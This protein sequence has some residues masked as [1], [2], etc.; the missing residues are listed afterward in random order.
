VLLTNDPLGVPTGQPTINRDE[1]VYWEES[2]IVSRYE[3]GISIIGHYPTD[4]PL[5]YTF[6]APSM[7]ER[8]CQAMGTA[9]MW[10]IL[11]PEVVE[12]SDPYIFRYRSPSEYESGS[13]YICGSNN[14]AFSL[15]FSSFIVDVFLAVF[16]ADPASTVLW[17]SS[18]FTIVQSSV[19]ITGDCIVRVPPRYSNRG[20]GGIEYGVKS[21][22]DSNVTSSAGSIL[23]PDFRR[24]LHG[25]IESRVPVFLKVAI[26]DSIKTCKSNPV[27]DI[28][29][30]QNPVRHAIV[31]ASSS[32]N[33]MA[34][35][36][37]MAVDGDARTQWLSSYSNTR[38]DPSPWISIHFPFYF[39]ISEYSF[40]SKG[41]SDPFVGQRPRSWE[42][43]ASRDGFT[44]K[45]LD[46]RSGK[47]E[48]LATFEVAN[49]NEFYSLYRFHFNQNNGWSWGHSCDLTVALFEINFYGIITCLS[50]HI[51][52]T[53]ARLCDCDNLC[54][55][56]VHF[57][58]T[59]LPT[60]TPTTIPQSS[61][62]T[63]Q[64]S[65][66]REND[67]RY[68]RKFPGSAHS[69][70]PCLGSLVFHNFAEGFSV[71]C[72]QYRLQN[73]Y[74]L[75][76]ASTSKLHS[77]INK[78]V[79]SSFFACAYGLQSK[80]SRL[81]ARVA[82]AES[83]DGLSTWIFQ[84]NLDR[85]S[86]EA[87]NLAHMRALLFLKGASIGYNQSVTVLSLNR[88]AL[89]ADGNILNQTLCHLRSTPFL[90][91]L[92]SSV[93]APMNV[94]IAHTSSWNTV[95]ISE[96]LLCLLSSSPSSPVPILLMLIADT[97]TDDDISSVSI[98]AAYSDW[99]TGDSTEEGPKIIVYLR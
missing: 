83:V 91:A 86:I 94:H 85:S 82:V 74:V 75:L 17:F 95:D 18:N 89:G 38:C 88:D 66:K 24:A 6:I 42:L 84:M 99:Y 69:N 40:L 51:Y 72:L 73:E 47:N 68:F 32:E 52:N 92:A 45:T 60:S 57:K 19:G 22:C 90:T 53:S 33:N 56:T 58:P 16:I 3:Q 35:N 13:Q 2:I 59:K 15:T 78:T 63:S 50:G 28:C 46:L 26:L 97:N 79:F 41:D 30:L 10:N 44:W 67:N 20:I 8:G 48:E 77:V 29:K 54:N 1:N 96:I 9:D 11:Q 65:Y 43:Q 23:F 25:N 4:L 21:V 36:A 64:P 5:N 39:I 93:C 71:N 76:N 7:N 49:N 61:L 98:P 80:V 12:F 27:V 62:P 37:S 14:S 87:S 31:N 55:S 70:T 34:L 81:I